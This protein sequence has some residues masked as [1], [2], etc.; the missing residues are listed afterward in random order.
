MERRTGYEISEQEF[1]RLLEDP[2]A[3]RRI[4]RELRT[5]GLSVDA[6]DPASVRETHEAIQ[7]D[8][9]HQRSIYQFAMDLWR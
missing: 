8:A 1:V 5:W 2:T 6:D 4:L 7:A 3:R 9:S